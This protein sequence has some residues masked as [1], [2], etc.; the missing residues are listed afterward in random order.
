MHS[1]NYE[2][3]V[4]FQGRTLP[5]QRLTNEDMYASPDD[6]YKNSY[7]TTKSAPMRSRRNPAE[8]VAYR[9]VIKLNLILDI[10]HCQH[11]RKHPIM[12]GEVVNDLL[13]RI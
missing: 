6:V 3:N 11:H 5:P 8:S 1:Y 10:N 13:E 9:H 2:T 4:L 12:I 7:K